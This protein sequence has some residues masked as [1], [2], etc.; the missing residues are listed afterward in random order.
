MRILAKLFASFFILIITSLLVILVLLHT[1]HSTQ[2]F[3]A[4]IT[5][6]L[7]GTLTAEQVDYHWQRPLHLT[8]TQPNYQYGHQLWHANTVRVQFSPN[9]WSHL[10][11]VRIDGLS[12]DLTDSAMTSLDML[13]A[14]LSI[15]RVL[16]NNLSLQGQ[17]WQAQQVS[18]Q[19]DQWHKGQAP[20]GSVRGRAQWEAKQVNW[21]GL[22]A[23]QLL[24]D[25]TPTPTG[26]QFRGVSF[27]WQRA[28]IS[29][30]GHWQPGTLALTQLTLSDVI[31]DSE[32]TYQRVTNT[33]MQWPDTTTLTVDRTDIRHLSADTEQF[34]VNGLTLS[35]EHITVAPDSPWWQQ[36]KLRASFNADY[37]RWRTQTWEQP[38]GDIERR[39]E[40]WV[41]NQLTSQWQEGFV[42]LSGHFSKRH[43]QIDRLQA[44]RLTLSHDIL[45][46]LIE[47]LPAWPETLSIDD[48]SL[49]HNQW[50]ALSR[51]FPIKISGIDVDGHALRLQPFKQWRL[52]DGSLTA[53]ASHASI[54][55]Q[56]LAEPYLRLDAEKGQLILHQLLLGFPDG[57]LAASGTWDLSTPSQP[58]S[59]HLDGLQIPL[60][61]YQAWFD[62]PL[63][64]TGFH[65]IEA[66]WSGL[67]AD[68]KSFNVGLNGEMDI[69]FLDA[70][71]H[72]D[73]DTNWATQ[74]NAW[75]QNPSLKK[76][77]QQAFPF[78]T[79]SIGAD[80]GQLIG[81]LQGETRLSIQWPLYRADVPRIR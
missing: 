47:T 68:R 22:Q 28:A 29:A 21:H 7:P 8:L 57:Q 74:I 2:V 48:L 52:T 50:L 25:A 30:Q 10:Q 71:T 40:S 46:P 39:G 26:W 17:G 19:L 43:W 33:L 5:P 64:L 23:T 16:F 80:R 3:T 15:G 76:D 56:W 55:Q 45:S 11:W 53:S 24:V 31:V 44:N 32:D 72:A 54:N 62:W 1:R 63:P 9:R 69:T 37:V 38:L 34:S 67:A 35:A 70:K 12:F 41:I 18:A 13:P 51:Q 66:K 58:W 81:T 65:D 59:I 73:S 4:L 20:L 75:L 42:G 6:V 49:K 14:T 60:S 36:P 79:L 27:E 77:K 61:V 78:E